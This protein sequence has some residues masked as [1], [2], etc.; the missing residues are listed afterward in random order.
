MANTVE[1]TAADGKVERFPLQYLFDHHA[2]VVN[3]IG[4]QDLSRSMG[5]ANQLWIASSTAKLFVRDIVKI[6]FTEES[7][8]PEVPSFEEEGMQ[9]TNRP[10]VSA[11][12][13]MKEAYPIG[14]PIGFEGY[15]N[16]YDKAIVG[17]QFSLDNGST[18]TT[19]ETE[20][21]TSD[22]W[23]YWHFEY[24]PEKTG[25]YILKARSVNVDGKAS[26]LAAAVR[27]EVVKPL[28]PL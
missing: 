13:E 8:P 12:T 14:E 6:E 18:W 24:T 1:F 9:F 15:A 25:V 3:R 19:Y 2:M 11:K 20:G 17:I 10:N 27:F 16:D 26:P 28:S 22:R 21:A 23:V 5:G 4:G 7:V